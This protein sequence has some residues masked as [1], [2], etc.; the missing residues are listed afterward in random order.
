ML[1][2]LGP[3]KLTGPR[4][5]RVANAILEHYAAILWAVTALTIAYLMLLPPSGDLLIAFRWAD[6]EALQGHFPATLSDI[7]LSRGVGYKL[8][9]YICEGLA[10]LRL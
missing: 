3:I 6:L 1:N 2:D 7:W 5:L 10:R 9:V 4:G 8:A